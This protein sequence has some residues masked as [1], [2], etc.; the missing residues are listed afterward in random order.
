MP[1]TLPRSSTVRP[2][3]ATISCACDLDSSVGS[4][5][6]FKQRSALRSRPTSRLGR[7]ASRALTSTAS[8][9]SASEQSLR[10][11]ISHIGHDESRGNNNGLH[12]Y[13]RA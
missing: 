4:L 6:L 11:A 13:S 2:S 12:G 7:D 10:C 5:A 3:S 8:G 1:F 9:T